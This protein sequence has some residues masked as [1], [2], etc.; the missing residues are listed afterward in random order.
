MKRIMGVALMVVVLSALATAC[1]TYWNHPRKSSADFGED[2]V[3]CKEVAAQIVQ[4][5]PPPP[6]GVSPALA[7]N[8]QTDQCLKDLGWVKVTK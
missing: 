7:M 1:T 3:R 8:Y 2:L 4:A 6:P 5:M